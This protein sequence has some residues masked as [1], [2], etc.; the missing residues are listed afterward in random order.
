[1]ARRLIVKK[2]KGD[3][4]QKSQKKKQ[5]GKSF[6]RAAVVGL[7]GG[8]FWGSIGLIC[9]LL[10]FSIVGPELLFAPFPL[11]AWK[12]KIG[13]EFLAIAGLVVLSLILALCYQFI[14]SRFKSFWIGICF[15]LLL[16]GIVFF[17]LRPFLPGL[18]FLTHLGWNTLSTTTCL[19][20]LYGLF[21]GY[22]ISFEV[23]E[24]NPDPESYS[25]E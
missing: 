4:G 5:T 7:F 25:K 20:L 18:P 1:M 8:A 14:L 15:G 17:A 9:K 12:N 3:P 11:P 21:I 2:K 10:N 13:G 6:G 22:S 23:E 19:F 16:W 24:E